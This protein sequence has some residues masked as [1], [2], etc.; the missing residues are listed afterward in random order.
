MVI[1]ELRRGRNFTE[2]ERIISEFIL[3]HPSEFQK[4]STEELGKATF[5]SKSTVIRLCKK[6]N[7]L[8]Y[9][10]L[11]K[12]LYS[13]L[14]E[15]RILGKDGITYPTLCS[16]STDKEIGNLLQQVYKK[17]I[18]EVNLCN[19]QIIISRIINQISKM[20]MI[21]LYS[22]GLGYATLEIVAY[23][24]NS[25]GIES[26]VSSA[27]NKS[28][29]ISAKKKYKIMALVVSISGNNSFIINIAKAL[30]HLGIY[31]VG[32][33]GPHSDDISKY[34]DELI[35]IP[36]DCFVP[37]MYAISVMHSINYIFDMIFTRLL[38][39]RCEVGDNSIAKRNKSR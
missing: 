34:C 21:E 7:V 19:N 22:T 8:G 15:E 3:N 38:A 33:V 16:K 27:F 29:L 28:H 13:E 23:R 25:I 37:E 10:E 9:Q 12:I 14:N 24:F 5:T 20:E 2:N 35:N 17:A 11:K 32:V 39:N 36:T 6:L 30:R 4:M 18:D 1:D 31:L 26:N